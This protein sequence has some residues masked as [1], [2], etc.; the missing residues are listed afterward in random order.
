MK[1]KFKFMDNISI[2]RNCVKTGNPIFEGDRVKLY[3]TCPY[4]NLEYVTGFI[5]YNVDACSFVLVTEDDGME[6]A[7]YGEM[8]L[9]SQ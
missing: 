1:W 4:E 2:Q 3:Q 9:C 5:V 7:L 6:F 8:E